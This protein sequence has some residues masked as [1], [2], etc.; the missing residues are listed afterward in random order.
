MDANR[1]QPKPCLHCFA[2]MKRCKNSNLNHPEL[3]GGNLCHPDLFLFIEP[4]P[5]PS[6]GS[7]EVVKPENGAV[8]AK[9]HEQPHFRDS[10]QPSLKRSIVEERSGG[11]ESD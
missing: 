7:G 9:T 4:P 11:R 10:C 1:T 8:R 6:P 2:S 3:I 5:Q